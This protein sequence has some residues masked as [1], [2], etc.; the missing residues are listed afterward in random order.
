MYRYRTGRAGPLLS[1]TGLFHL[2][3]TAS[4]ENLFTHRP[5]NQSLF[6]ESVFESQKRNVMKRPLCLLIL[7][8]FI[9][10]PEAGVARDRKYRFGELKVADGHVLVNF[11]V[12]DLLNTDVIHALQKGMT[13][14]VEYEVQIWRD[15]SGWV[16]QLVD[17]DRFRMK[18]SYD[19][20]EKRF[21]LAEKR[22]EYRL[23]NEDRVR[24]KCSEIVDFPL[25][26]VE[27]LDEGG[28]YFV[29]VRVILQPMS[30]ESYEEIKRWLTGEVSEL[31]PKAI[32]QTRDPGKKAGD[33]FMGLV[34]N[35][36][37]FGDRIL[38]AKGPLFTWS[39]GRITVLL[40]K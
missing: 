16:D 10:L 4:R 29:T 21:I 38:N 37:G 33:W 24:E 7:I 28:R 3:G 15:R 39:E 19:A 23:M 18:V 5:G 32:R 36:T 6:R 27:N 25:T 12:R 9:L 22:G 8:F 26:A 31:N 2:K 30:V 35:L 20:W 14:A 17:E 13:A 1:R 40:E 11:Q 34:L